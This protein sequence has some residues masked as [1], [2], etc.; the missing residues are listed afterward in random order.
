[1]YRLT[2]TVLEK[3]RE[4]P[5]RSVS[6][7]GAW[8]D[9]R[10]ILLYQEQDGTWCILWDNTTV[11]F[12]REPIDILLI[13]SGLWVREKNLLKQYMP[14]GICRK[15]YLLKEETDSFG[16]L[17]REDIWVWYRDNTIVIYNQDGIQSEIHLA[18]PDASGKQ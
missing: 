15:E 12:G 1:M 16:S 3:I 7:V 4:Y 13:D 6:V 8:P 9:G 2:G 10:I 18:R 17:D 5:Y 14:D 11:L